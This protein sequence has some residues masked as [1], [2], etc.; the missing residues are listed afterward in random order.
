M[1]VI[2]VLEAKVSLKSLA[3]DASCCPLTAQP[4]AL[5]RDTAPAVGGWTGVTNP[6][7]LRVCVSW[8]AFV[9]P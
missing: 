4:A 1:F 8:L 3:S 7:R 2:L 9:R 6:R 5:P